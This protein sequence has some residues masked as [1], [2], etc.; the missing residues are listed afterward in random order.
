[1]YVIGSIWTNEEY[2]GVKMGRLA[3]RGARYGG[4]ALDLID[5]SLQLGATKDDILRLVSDKTVAMYEW[6]YRFI[7]DGLYNQGMWQD[8]WKGANLYNGI[9]DGKVFCTYVQQ[10]DCFLIHGWPDDPAMASYLPQIDDMG[11][12]VVPKAVSFELDSK[13]AYAF[14]GTRSIST[15][16]WWW[17]IPKTS[18]NAVLAY[19]L[20]RFI[21]SRENNA[22]ECSKF[23]MIPVRKDIL[24]NLPQ[25][26]DEGWVGEIFKVSI[27]QMQQN[28]LTT[29]PL[30]KQYNRISLN[31]IEAWYKLCVEEP[32]G[33]FTSAALRAQLQKE[34]EPAQKEI[35]GSD[36]PAAQ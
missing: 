22:V 16:G 14:E 19:D 3:H 25:V 17:G 24:S 9:K 34:F 36:F 6:E 30:I 23:G 32:T 1:M 5:R 2:N 8:L 26:F 12:C 35:L 27:E 28:E 33:T 10:I 20:A 4:T 7:K 18:P 15:G 13:G 29:V 31:F 11:I 21:T